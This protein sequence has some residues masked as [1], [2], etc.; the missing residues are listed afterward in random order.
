MAITVSAVPQFQLTYTLTET[1]PSTFGSL[2]DSVG[3]A[4]SS[5]STVGGS[6]ITFSDG[7]GTGAVNMG[8]EITGTLPS[9][10]SLDFNM[11]SFEKNSYGVAGTVNFSSGIKGI[12]VVN[13]YSGGLSGWPASG[14]SPTDMPRITISATGISGYSGLF[15]ANSGHLALR[16]YSTFAFSDYVGIPVVGDQQILTLSDVD[17]SGCSYEI[18]VVGVATA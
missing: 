13:T 12:T 15:N 18:T 5:E 14:Y 1:S 17:G 8:A 2:F 3:S 10:G 6:K 7:T 4:T 9:G 11:T 16:P